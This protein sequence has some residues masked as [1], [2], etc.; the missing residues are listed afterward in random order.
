MKGGSDLSLNSVRFSLEKPDLG[1]RVS[2]S[3]IQEIVGTQKS[4]GGFEVSEVL[5]E[6]EFQNTLKE[7]EKLE[8]TSKVITS[9]ASSLD[10]P[11][12][13]KFSNHAV[14]RMIHRG[15]YFQ[16]QDLDRLSQAVQKAES[17]GAKDTLVLMNNSALIVSVKNKTV[18][19]VMDKAHLKDNV[20]TNIDST[21]VV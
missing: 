17:K 3:S 13:L 5:K 8:S 2:G 6:K 9:K 18:V 14:E 1:N 15:I 10:S 21:V 11:S 16:P 7:I 12:G 4:K 19:T 20:F